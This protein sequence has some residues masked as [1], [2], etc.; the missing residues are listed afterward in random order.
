MDGVSD[1]R[2]AGMNYDVNNGI[3]MYLRKIERA[4]MNYGTQ[5]PSIYLFI[6]PPRSSTYFCPLLVY[7]KTVAQ[8]YHCISRLRGAC[9]Y[10]DMLAKL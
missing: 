5:D 1:L 10:G 2:D 9:N 8:Q 3:N 7:L 6:I 4:S